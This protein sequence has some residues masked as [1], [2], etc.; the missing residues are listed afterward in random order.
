MEN[1][2]RSQNYFPTFNKLITWYCTALDK[3]PALVGQLS[4]YFCVNII[5]LIFSLFFDMGFKDGI[6]FWFPFFGLFFNVF[7]I[8]N[9]PVAVLLSTIFFTSVALNNIVLVFFP[10]IRTSK[11]KLLIASLIVGLISFVSANIVAVS[12]FLK[13]P[14][15]L[16][17]G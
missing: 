14:L 7:L 1:Y 6:F 8:P 9:I 11:A 10:N 2:S 17:A 13:V 16:R 15:F 4:F 3:F 12:L 5:V